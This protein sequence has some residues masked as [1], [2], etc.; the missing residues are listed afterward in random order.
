MTIPVAPF[1]RHGVPQLG[2]TQ[3]LDTLSDRPMFRLAY[4]NLSDHESLLLN[5]SVAAGVS[6]GVR[7]YELRS[8]ND[9]PVVFQQGTY[10]PDSVFRWMGSIAMDRAGNIAV[11]YSASSSD[12]NPAIRYSGREVDD[13]PG[14]LRAENST[15]EGS[16]SQGSNLGRWGDYSSVTV[17]P[18]DDCVFWYTNEYLQVDG[19][20]NWNTRIVSFRFPSC[21]SD[22]HRLR[23]GHRHKR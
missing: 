18:V 4:R 2:T 11:G 23:N 7:W 17:D 16:G 15:V 3:T 8:P 6:I 13:P 12:I 10:S 5:H 1:S 14:I 9:T 22:G 20:F 21:D 19:R